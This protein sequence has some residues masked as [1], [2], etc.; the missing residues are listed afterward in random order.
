MR[1]LVGM[2][3]PTPSHIT[4]TIISR[5]GPVGPWPVGPQAAPGTGRR[6]PRPKESSNTM[7]TVD[8]TRTHRQELQLVVELAD[9]RFAIASLLVTL[10]VP[11]LAFVSGNATVLFYVHVALGA[12]WF[13]F[14]FFFKFVMGPAFDA[15]PEEAAG[16]VN[17]QLVPKIVVLAEPLSV[18]VIGS[19]IG[20]AALLGYW[21]D[22]SI[23]LWG[24]LGIGLLMLINGFGPLH[25]ATTQMV[26]EMAAEEPD[27]TR[28]DEL[29]GKAL[30]WG[31][32]QTVFMLT[33]LTMMVGLRGLL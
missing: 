20:L 21:A 23:W 28:I 29:F 3:P 15:A 2:P 17:R 16:A 9:Q 14:D 1:Y 5:R 33:I 27:G 11:L 31:M 13:G 8:H 24:A 6:F 18:G 12:F 19:G 26:V 25:R 4:I 22:P 10:V 30:R 7:A 32:L